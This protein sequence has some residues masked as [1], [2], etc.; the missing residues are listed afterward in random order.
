MTL[1]KGSLYWKGLLKKKLLFWQE[2]RKAKTSMPHNDVP[3]KKY[4]K[5]L[6]KVWYFPGKNNIMQLIKIKTGHTL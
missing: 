6:S 4:D 3:T 2:P 1:G 5:H